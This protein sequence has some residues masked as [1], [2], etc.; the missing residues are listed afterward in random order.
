MIALGSD[1]PNNWFWRLPCSLLA[2]RTTL[3][4]DIGASPADIVYG[5]G[6]SIPGTLIQPRPSPED[7]AAEN[8]PNFL[9]NLRLEVA[10]LQPTATSAHR[11]PRVH[12]PDEL[13]RASHVLVRRGGIQ[14]SFGAPYSGPHKVISR[15]EN[16]YRIAMPGG[17]PE[18]ISISRLK[19]AV[20]R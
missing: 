1:E 19:P 5:E 16:S 3:K 9:N 18:N 17:R 7:E 20:I 2:I 8:R 10:R 14:P 15:S 13:G 4:P 12:I 11:R 6:L